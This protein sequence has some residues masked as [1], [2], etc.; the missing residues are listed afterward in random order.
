MQMLGSGAK[1]CWSNPVDQA[2][3]V[4]LKGNHQGDPTSG[5]RVERE[6]SYHRLVVGGVVED[7][8]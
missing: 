3:S 4:E 5:L 1:N 2:A 7:G 8:G 6:D